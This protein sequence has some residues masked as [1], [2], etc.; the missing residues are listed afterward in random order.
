[1]QDYEKLIKEHFDIIRKCVFYDKERGIVVLLATTPGSRYPY[2]YPRDAACATHL[3]NT[4]SAS[5]FLV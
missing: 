2:F 5:D 1:M 4:L 3:L